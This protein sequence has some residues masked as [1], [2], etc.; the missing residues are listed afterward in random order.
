VASANVCVNT[1]DFGMQTTEVSVWQRP[2]IRM[3][4]SIHIDVWDAGEGGIQCSGDV[5]LG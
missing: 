4:N 2:K 5:C 3:R 1:P